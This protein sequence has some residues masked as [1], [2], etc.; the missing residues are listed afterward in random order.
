MVSQLND[1][2]SVNNKIFQNTYIFNISKELELK[3]TT[4]SNTVCSFLDVLFNANGELKC[5]EYDKRDDFLLDN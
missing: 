2:L 1:L 4:E 3:E 5:Q